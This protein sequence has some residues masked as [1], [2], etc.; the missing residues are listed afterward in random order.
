MP[1]ALIG[2]ALAG[3]LAHREPFGFLSRLEVAVP[4]DRLRQLIPLSTPFPVDLDR[5]AGTVL[6]LSPDMLRTDGP[7]RPY[8]CNG[9][10]AR[11]EGQDACAVSGP[12]GRMFH[13]GLALDIY[14]FDPTPDKE[15]NIKWPGDGGATI[16]V[17]QEM[18]QPFHTCGF[19]GAL[20]WCPLDSRSV[21]D[22]TGSREASEHECVNG[23]WQRRQS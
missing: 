18:F 15:G 1:Y 3:Q 12:V 8:T 2:D 13:S 11:S 19:L 23:Q 10:L 16:R 7:R 14:A 21:A 22:M 9:R 6:V 4:A 5:S 20:G 17:P